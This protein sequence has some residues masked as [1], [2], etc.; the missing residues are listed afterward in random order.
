V[1]NADACVETSVYAEGREDLGIGCHAHSENGWRK[2]VE[3]KGNVSSLIAIEASRN[4]PKSAAENASAGKEREAQKQK[5]VRHL[6]AQ[7]PC[8][9]LAGGLH[10]AV[11]GLAKMVEAALSEEIQR[12]GKARDAVGQHAIADVA[13]SGEVAG[14][15]CGALPHFATTP[16]VLI[17][18]I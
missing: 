18:A 10:N 5:D 17:V 2:T 15:G 7:F 13:A 6:V 11:F 3:G 12:E 14:Q 9:E 4:P 1:R 8:A 16:R